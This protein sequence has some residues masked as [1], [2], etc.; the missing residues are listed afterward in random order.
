MSF[1]KIGFL[2]LLATLAL[3]SCKDDDDGNGVISI[4]IA[5]RDEQ[6]S[7]DNGMLV[8]YLTTHYYNASAFVNNPNPKIADLIISDTP[9]GNAR[10]IDSVDIK[11]VRFAD[12]DYEIYILKLNEGGGETTNFSDKVRVHYEGFLL[13]GTI[14]D[15]AVTP[16]DFNLVGDG[17]TIGSVIDGWKKALV[18]FK[19]AEN[20]TEDGGL[21]NYEN[22]GV[23]VMFMPS[24]LAYFNESRSKIPAYSPLIFKF[25]LLQNFFTDFD[26]DGIPS[27][28]EKIL[29]DPADSQFLDQFVVFADENEKDDD[30]DNNGLW[31][32]IDPDDDGD[33]ILT[34]DEIKVRTITGTKAEVE[35]AIL[36]KDEERVRVYKDVLNNN[37]VAT[38]IEFTDTDDNGT[39]DYLEDNI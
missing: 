26:D 16:T 39:P 11:P 29:K 32:F 8:D 22:H 9:D 38:I 34:K 7:I 3:I 4:P 30:T 24:G 5:D 23:G 27:H 10:L 2:I 19:S 13:D 21:I 31:D 25:E 33:G 35:N 15:S 20:F 37:Y 6:Q 36:N 1:R 17:R 14:F 18:D 28:L 12:T